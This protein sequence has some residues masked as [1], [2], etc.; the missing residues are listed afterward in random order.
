VR[1]PALPNP[2]LP[3]EKWEPDTL[4]AC[5]IWGEARGEDLLGKLAVA[6][7]VLNRLIRKGLG[8]DGV[9]R[10]V[11]AKWQFSCWNVNDPNSEKMVA[12]I[13]HSN[14]VVWD[15]CATIAAL[16]LAGCTVD[17]TKGASHYCVNSLWETKQ[18]QWYSPDEIDK[19][20]TTLTAV[21]G[22]HTF[23]KAP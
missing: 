15:A 7:V 8:P 16:A 3:P 13:K 4:L 14:A 19:G 23:A 17:P 18:G 10:I 11:L 20:R 5:T 21:I 1:F 9:A 6:H 12:P 22:N 2:D